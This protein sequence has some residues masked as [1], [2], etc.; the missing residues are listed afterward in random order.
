M[1][2]PVLRRDLLH[3]AL[4]GNVELISAF[5][6]LWEAAETL[7]RQMEAVT[8]STDAAQ[9]AGVI[10]TGPTDAFPGSRVLAEGAGIDLVDDGTTVQIRTDQT[11]PKVEGGHPVRLIATGPS[12]L[13]LPALGT[14]ATTGGEETLTGKTLT[15]P[16][17][18]G[19]IDYADDTAAA[20]GGVPIGGSYRTGSALKVRVA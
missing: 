18:N 19:L 3:Q 7:V 10:T 17:M 5:E 12:H 16:K 11:V 14:L 13:I 9:Q 2:L 15:S 20:A 4:G 8:N 1:T 6:Q